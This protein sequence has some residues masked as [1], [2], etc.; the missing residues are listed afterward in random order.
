METHPVRTDM[1]N[2][3]IDCN[4]PWDCLIIVT[5]RIFIQADGNTPRYALAIRDLEILT[6]PVM[7]GWVILDA[8]VKGHRFLVSN[9]RC[10]VGEINLLESCRWG[11]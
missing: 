10:T 7:R 11:F 5:Y 4:P 9:G 2:M 3:R 8:L 1:I 6:R